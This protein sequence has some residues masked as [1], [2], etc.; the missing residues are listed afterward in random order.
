MA[1]KTSLRTCR[2]K[3]R[4]FKRSDDGALRILVADIRFGYSPW[5]LAADI[6][7]DICCGYSLRILVTDTH[8]RV[9]VDISH[10]H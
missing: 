1:R 8:C 9:T 2:K 6:V 4:S 7:G 5:I 10:G 3:L